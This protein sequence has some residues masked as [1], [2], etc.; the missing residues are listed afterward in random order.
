MAMYSISGVTIPRF[1]YAICVTASPFFARS[2][3]RFKPGKF[4]N[5]PFDSDRIRAYCSCP[6]VR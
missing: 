2:G 6:L 4:F 5:P 1:A 3:F